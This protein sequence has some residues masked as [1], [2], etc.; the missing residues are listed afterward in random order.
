MGSCRSPVLRC[1]HRA[2]QEAL[3]DPV[4]GVLRVDVEQVRRVV[5]AETRDHLCAVVTGNR[6]R[7]DVDIRVLGLELRYRSI[8]SVLLGRR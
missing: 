6:L 4:L 7:L 5:R 8:K 3:V 1:S 2:G